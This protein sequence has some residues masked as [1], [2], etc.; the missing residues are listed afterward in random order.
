MLE[1]RLVFY[2][3]YSNNVIKKKQRQHC[4][5]A[6]PPQI[7]YNRTQTPVGFF[8]KILYY[9]NDTYYTLGLDVWIC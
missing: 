2:F 6:A 8:W 4:V 7:K 5:D 9:N 1:K 3:W